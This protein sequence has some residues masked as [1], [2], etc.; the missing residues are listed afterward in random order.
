MNIVHASIGTNKYKT[1]IRTSRNSIIADEP[2]SLGGSDLGFS[3]TQLLCSSLAACTSITL[4][5][6]ANHK[7]WNVV[8][9]LVTVEYDKN[10]ETDISTF[11]RKIEIR[12]AITDEQ[13]QR[14]HDV[15]NKCPVHKILSSPIQINTTVV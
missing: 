8:D 2:L 12:G 15:A 1:T 3:P 5:M 9:I 7:N 11:T 4:R 6:Y 13:K 10:N 14:L